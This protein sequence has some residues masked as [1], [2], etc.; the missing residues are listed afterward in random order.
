MEEGPIT[1]TLNG[2]SD[3][4]FKS[5]YKYTLKIIYKVDNNIFSIQIQY[6]IEHKI[7]ISRKNNENASPARGS[8]IILCP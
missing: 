6:K 3:A 4:L 7:I 2:P 5:Y 8:L 1:Y